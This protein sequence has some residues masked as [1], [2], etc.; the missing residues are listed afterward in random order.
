MIN[1]LTTQ[2][3][4]PLYFH[5]AI[6]LYIFWFLIFSGIL[7]W[8]YY[9]PTL[10][11]AWSSV[12][13]ISALP[14]I[15][16]GTVSLADP[17]SGIPYGSI[18]RGIHRYGAA[19]MMIAT[20]LHML[21]VY[22]TDRHRSWRWFPWITGVALLVLVLFVGITGYL[23]VW[24]NRAYALTVWT[25]SFIAAIPLIGASLSNFFIAGDVIT[26]Y[27]LIRFFFFHVGGAA[28]I[29]VLMWTH[30]IRLKYPVVTPSRS[31]N[32]LVLGFILVAAGAIPA[33]NITQE[34]IAKYPSLSDQAAYIASDAPANIGSLVSNVR[35]DVWYM[36]PYYLIEKLG[37]TGAW[38]VLGVSTILLIVAP[39]YPKDRRDNIAEVIEAKCTGCTFC[40]LDCPFEAITMQDRAPGSKFKLI[41]VVQE[42][43][44]SECGI[45]VGA[46]PFQAIE[47]PNMDSKAIDGDVLALLKQGV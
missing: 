22:F 10:E 23:L 31:T 11:R 25:Q 3:H 45:C 39:F 19:G 28:L 14:I 2:E 46:C 8:M 35:Y 6:P 26:D 36:F 30:F 5:G 13:Y 20:I 47:L 9:I 17:A 7:L 4:N 12:N 44:C 32:F 21:R 42:A 18:I 41:A 33:I 38:W 16:K 40:S 1:F 37:I 27:T 29:F 24:D 15:Q 43:R 34:L